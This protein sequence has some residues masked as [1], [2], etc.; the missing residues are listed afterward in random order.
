MWLQ[1]ICS[2]VLRSDAA[3]LLAYEC[4]HI[5]VVCDGLVISSYV[6]KSCLSTCHKADLK[7]LKGALM[8]VCH[9]EP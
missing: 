8:Y 9:H 5:L 2:M 4:V 3:I 1:L 6:V 7:V